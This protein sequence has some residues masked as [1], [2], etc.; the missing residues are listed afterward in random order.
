MT[1]EPTNPGDL[2]AGRTPFEFVYRGSSHVDEED[3]AIELFTDVGRGEVGFRG[4][5]TDPVRFR[6]AF[7]TL[8]EIVKSDFRYVPRDRSAY[9]AWKSASQREG[10]SRS[11]FEQQK[12]YFEWLRE[13]DPHAWVVLDPIVTAHP[14]V[15]M[16][17]V[18]SKDEGSYARLE[19]D[20][21]LFELDGEVTHGTTNVD[22][23]AELF[24]GVSRLREGRQTTVA[25]SHDAFGMK[26]DS[27]AVLEKRIE[28]PNSWIHGFLQVQSAAALAD[29]TFEISPMNL[30][31]A[32]RHLR[33]H[34]D[35][36]GEGR[37]IRAELTPGEAPRLVLEPWELVLESDGEVYRGETAEVINIWG[38]RRLST[39]HR[40]LPYVDRVRV[41]L[42]G[43]GM[44]GFWIF[45]CGPIT[46][47][48]GLTGFVASNWSQ[49]VHLDV[50]LPSPDGSDAWEAVLARLQTDW[51]ATV[52]QL[53][54]ELPHSRREV[55]AALQRACRKGLAI[56]DLDGGSYRY[57]P[58]TK[59]PIDDDVVT[60]RNVREREACDLV[61]GQGGRVELTSEIE[62][63][64]RGIEYRAKVDVVAD[65][66][67]YETSF[68]LTPDGRLYR[69]DCSCTFFRQHQM[70]EGPCAHLYALRLVVARRE[71][72]ALQKRGTSE[73]TAETRT[74]VRRHD[75]GEDV[76]KVTLDDR[77]MRIEWGLRA[78]RDRR[79]QRLM[80]N[81][82]DD[83]RAAYLE[84]IADLESKGFLDASR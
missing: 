20:W 78:D 21:E 1:D 2:S 25:M 63:V 14:D 52:D 74:Y 48:M 36:K 55:L 32:L 19:V 5:V 51:I 58:L 43:S 72:E 67:E 27:K 31:N 75:G 7:S 4:C 38:R 64:G 54:Q 11:A 66:R 53:E 39:I 10:A 22:Y 17:E 30:Y 49:A 35:Q 37:S 40:I 13:N 9:L 26:T 56:Y 69:P 8:Y 34:A 28:V 82:V 71:K 47:K 59:D 57:R 42:I 77:Q 15:L 46:L 80:F 12:S 6:E 65:K 23:S 3:D 50:M 33:L 81:A 41:K 45:E 16:F 62:V 29:V 79:F 24:D 44:P 83:A 61:E 84:R 76:Y 68:Q 18:F 60:F 73:I 70:K